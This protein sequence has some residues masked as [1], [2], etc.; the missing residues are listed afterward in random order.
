MVLEQSGIKRQDMTSGG[1]RRGQLSR[2]SRGQLRAWG[3][4]EVEVV[5]TVKVWS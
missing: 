5:F 3:R 4:G 2:V 1:E